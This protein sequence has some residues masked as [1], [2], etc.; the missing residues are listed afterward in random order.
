MSQ[1]TKFKVVQ[2]KETKKVQLELWH[3]F[4][5]KDDDWL[6]YEKFE[7]MTILE[8]KELSDYLN[9]TLKKAIEKNGIKR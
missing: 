7:D 4:G 8:L 2:N 6:C 3:K 9:M 1:S 5:E